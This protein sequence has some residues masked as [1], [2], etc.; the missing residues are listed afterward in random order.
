MRQN[1]GY[2][3]KELAGVPYLLPYGQAIAE[4]KNGL[5]LNETALFFWN[6]LSE[7][8]SLQEII[9][10][11][12]EHFNISDSDYSSFCQDVENLIKQFISILYRL[13]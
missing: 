5:Q 9:S 11:G 1:P 3:L 13:F 12:K 6:L 4:E 2:I 8:H 10:Y 7:D